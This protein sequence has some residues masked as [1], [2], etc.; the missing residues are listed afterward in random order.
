VESFVGKGVEGRLQEIE[1]TSQADDKTVDFAEGLETKDFG[2]VVGYGG[3]VEWAVYDW[4]CL[5]E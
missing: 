2:R 5:L 4:R 3:V 1:E